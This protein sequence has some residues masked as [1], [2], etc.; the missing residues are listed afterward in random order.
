[1]KK[2]K[3]KLKNFL[4]ASLILGLLAPYSNASNDSKFRASFELLHGLVIEEVKHLDFGTVAINGYQQ[5]KVEP[6]DP[7]AAVFNAKGVPNARVGVYVRNGSGVMYRLGTSGQ[8]QEDRILFTDFKFGG[9][10]GASSYYGD[11]DFDSNGELNNI[12]VGASAY[13]QSY[14]KNGAYKGT[15]SLVMYYI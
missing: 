15:V 2:V 4:A 14:N 5:V 1:M 6:D 7:G 12:R 10:L 13:I 8:R 3:S 11:G 9:S